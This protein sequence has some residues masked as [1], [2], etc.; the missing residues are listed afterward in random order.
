MEGWR[1]DINP[2]RGKMFFLKNMAIWKGW[3]TPKKWICVSSCPTSH[4]KVFASKYSKDMEMS[5]VD[6]ERWLLAAYD[7]KATPKNQLHNRA[8]AATPP[9]V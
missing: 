5:C 7:F 1:E 2:S 9:K 3:R 8:T 4:R 6:K